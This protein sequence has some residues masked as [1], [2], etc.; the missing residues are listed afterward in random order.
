MA[1]NPCDVTLVDYALPCSTN[2]SVGV[3]QFYIANFSGASVTTW[4]YDANN[5]ITGA[6]PSGASPHFKSVEM[7]EQLASMTEVTTISPAGN[8]TITQ[9]VEL[10]LIG[11]NYTNRNYAQLLLSGKFYVI[12]KN[13]EGVYV[14]FG[15]D[16]G[17]K[18]LSLNANTGVGIS[19]E[20]SIRIQL[21]AL[22]RDLAPTISETFIAT[23]IA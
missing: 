15:V 11:Q 19:D 14:L 7:P 9:T 22:N 2:I 1:A 6:T 21:S 23:L 10:V 20:N 4:V 18:K 13:M 16:K 3:N 12:T 5:V 17:M 8:L